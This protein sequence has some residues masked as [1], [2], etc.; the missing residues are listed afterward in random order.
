MTLTVTTTAAAGDRNR[1]M[2]ASGFGRTPTLSS[3]SWT[4]TRG[5]GGGST[6]RGSNDDD[7]S[8]DNRLP[9]IGVPMPVVRYRT[10]LDFPGINLPPLLRD[11]RADHP[12]RF[13]DALYSKCKLLDVTTVL[14]PWED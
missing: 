5:G 1:G 13:N 9:P 3:L 11:A 14:V 7:R 12:R 10:N 8:I 4:R 6:W 2:M